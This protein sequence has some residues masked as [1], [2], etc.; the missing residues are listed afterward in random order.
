MDNHWWSYSLTHAGSVS[1]DNYL[2]LGLCAQCTFIHNAA[3]DIMVHD[4]GVQDCCN[5]LRNM[6]ISTAILHPCVALAR[7]NYMT[8]GASSLHSCTAAVGGRAVCVVHCMAGAP[9]STCSAG[10]MQYNSLQ[11]W[12]RITIVLLICR[13]TSSMN[14]ER[15]QH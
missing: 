9:C 14:T 12:V 11:S 13:S 6:C 4:Q 7:W 5:N 15:T 8:R 1:A 2:V 10:A 3:Y